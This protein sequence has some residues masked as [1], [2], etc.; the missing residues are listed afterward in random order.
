[1]IAYSSECIVEL[2]EAMRHGDMPCL[3]GQSVELGDFVAMRV[4]EECIVTIDLGNITQTD[5][6]GIA[7]RTVY[8]HVDA[9]Q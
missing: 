3:D 4:A 5:R 6:D 8:G 1:M 7:E 9:A 2:C